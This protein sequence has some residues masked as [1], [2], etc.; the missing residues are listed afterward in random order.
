MRRSV[1]LE[2]DSFVAPALILFNARGDYLL[3]LPAVRAIT[4]LFGER[5]T[6]IVRRGVPDVFYRDVE[7]GRFI[8]TDL[9]FSE[10]S[11]DARFNATELAHEMGHCDLLLSLNSWYARPM[12]QLLAT[13]QPSYSIGF[14]TPFDHSLPLDFGIHN[15]DL[16]FTLSQALDPSLS[17]EDFA[18]PPCLDGGAAAWADDLV[19]QLP[20]SSLLI[21]LHGESKADKSWK[22]DRFVSVLDHILERLPNAWV[23]DVGQERIAYD[24]GAHRDRVIP[25]TGMPLTHAM[26]IVSRSRF[27]LGVDSCFLHAADLFRVPGLALFGPTEPHEFGFRFAPSR[28][29][30]RDRM[31]DIGVTDVIAAANELLDETQSLSLV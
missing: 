6:L 26:A 10:Q 20:E 28:H 13:A 18:G 9:D 5:L 4:S 1:K 29:V 24:V 8:E 14:H 17:I 19:H 11:L 23:F 2:L 3:N 25:A 27:F 12:Q 21:T 7:V 30:K 15:A 16:G 31:D 22:T